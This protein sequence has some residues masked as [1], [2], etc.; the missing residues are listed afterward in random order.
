MIRTKG[1]LLVVMTFVLAVNGQNVELSSSGNKLHRIDWKTSL[2]SALQ[3]A[4]RIGKP[5]M[6]DFWA[7]WCAPCRAMDKRTY[8][9]KNVIEQ[10]KN[11]IMVKIDIEKSPEDAARYQ[12]ET[13]P[14]V[15]FLRADG[16]NISSFVGFRDAAGTLKSMKSALNQSK[17]K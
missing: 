16:S 3:E 8:P 7:T 14:K 5:I 1:L 9:N 12:V 2:E 4:E 15:V 6:I 10:A 11:F 17:Q 13:P